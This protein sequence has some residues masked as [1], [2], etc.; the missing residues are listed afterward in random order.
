[1]PIVVYSLQMPAGFPSGMEL[2]EEVSFSGFC[3]KRWAYPAADGTRVAPLILAKTAR[4]NPQPAP[5]A[6]Y[7]LPAPGTVAVA[8]VSS[9]LLAAGIAGLV[10]VSTRRSVLQG[11]RDAK[12]R[13]RPAVLDRLQG[14]VKPGVGP[15]LRALE[16]SE[17]TE[18][19]SDDGIAG[20][21]EPRRDS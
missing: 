10:Y 2:D 7:S 13:F 21:D 1:L 11:R 3:Y 16:D 8:L 4:W 19:A 18:N 15:S 12:K 20:R 9:V 14:E 6:A 17:A 5:P